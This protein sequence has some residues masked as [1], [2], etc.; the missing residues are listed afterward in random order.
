M[1]APPPGSQ[2]KELKSLMKA[3]T[4][5]IKKFNTVLNGLKTKFSEIKTSSGEMNKALIKANKNLKVLNEDRLK[6]FSESIKKLE[7]K[8]LKNFQN[9]LNSVNSK[10]VAKNAKPINPP[11]TKKK[12]DPDD[13]DYWSKRQEIL[14]KKQY[15]GMNRLFGSFG[16]TINSI[17]GILQESYAGMGTYQALILASVETFV[18]AVNRSDELEKKALGLGRNVQSLYKENSDILAK[19]GG[20][21]IENLAV[22]LEFY[23]MGIR[24]NTESLQKVG[25]R[26]RLTGGDYKL[27]AKSMASN[28]VSLRI[29]A[30]QAGK[31]AESLNESSIKNGMSMDD[32]VQSITGLGKELTMFS[33]KGM[34]Q[35]IAAAIGQL[36]AEAG[37]ASQENIQQVAKMLL[38]SEE[39]VA[40]AAAAGVQKELFALGT[41]EGA[42]KQNLDTVIEGISKAYD[43]Q[44]KAFDSAITA[45]LAIRGSLFESMAP[46]AELQTSIENMSEQQKHQER[47][48]RDFTNTIATINEELLNP[49]K[50][51]VV[52][53]MDTIKMF[54][55]ILGQLIKWGALVAG[56][57][58]LFKGLGIAASTLAKVT[59]TLASLNATNQQKGLNAF[60]GTIESIKSFFKDD[61]K[62]FFGK[63]GAIQIAT[64]NLTKGS[65]MKRALKGKGILSG[66]TRLFAGLGPKFLG[67]GGFLAK[68]LLRFI[69][70][71]GTAMLLWDLGKMTYDAL[72]GVGKNTEKTAEELERERQRRERIERQQ[73]E[74]VSTLDKTMIALINVTRNRDASL[75]ASLQTIAQASQTTARNT[76][77]KVEPIRLR[78][79]VYGN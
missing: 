62:E 8:D 33:A 41:K 13:L 11:E 75:N 74:T 61:I 39:G 47:V 24:E 1:T 19:L 5:T 59:G 58:A 32:L 9:A 30:E 49:I 72:K 38:N 79:D 71:L 27:F 50:D 52:A 57:A 56:T 28:M 18:N 14:L 51:F 76:V 29:N 43:K 10:S 37:I 25:N 65:V 64:K 16:D 23:S 54:A 3:L 60:E 70:F 4:G 66:L 20:D 21:S 31:L 36:Q 15:D 22:A 2:D 40:M 69:P 67:L 44:V 35:D 26:I 12:D 42:N 73:V 78:K 63:K 45:G 34:G 55:S 68:G 7:S 17:G 53:N 77:P 46:I 6:K 48:N